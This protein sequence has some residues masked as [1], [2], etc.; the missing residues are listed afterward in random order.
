MYSCLGVTC[1]QIGTHALGIKC[2]D[3]DMDKSL[4]NYAGYIPE[5]DVRNVSGMIWIVLFICMQILIS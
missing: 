5:S 3:E 1:S 4:M 2:D